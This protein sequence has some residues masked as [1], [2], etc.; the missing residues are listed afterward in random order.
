[1]I[2]KEE[3][4]MHS[5]RRDLPSLIETSRLILRPYQLGDAPAYYAACRRNREHLLPYEADNPALDVHTLE[6]A[7]DLMRDFEAAWANHRMFFLG[8]WHRDAGEWVAQVV[9]S[10]VSRQLP[11]LAVGYWVD[12]RSQGQG[13]V[14]E[15]VRAALGLA[16]DVLGAHRVR[17]MCDETNLRSI[18]VAERCGF[19]REACLRQASRV[20]GLDGTPHNDLIYGML[21]AEYESLA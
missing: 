10:F 6:D 16:F 19:A 1:M 11:E 2:H 5:G 20:R 17:L 15:A 18:R 13:Y 7:A 9:L 14:T 21:R 4:D 3:T 12:C 8:A